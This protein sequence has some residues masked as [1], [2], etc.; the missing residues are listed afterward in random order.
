MLTSER[1]QFKK[2]EKDDFK[3]LHEIFSDEEAMRYICNVKSEQETLNWIDDAIKSYE[4]NIF[5]PWAVLLK[6]TKDFIGYCG[7][8]LQKDIDGVD[9]IELLYGYKKQYW[10]M[11]YATESTQKIYRYVKTEFKMNRII[12]LIEIG[13]D[14]SENVVQKLGMTFEKTVR[15][16]GRNYKLYSIEE[17]RV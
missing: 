14:K 1:L 6:N 5:G 2:I 10:N 4:V 9:E 15:K 3:E 11:G 8:Y 12:S 17:S 13:N 7:L 16:W